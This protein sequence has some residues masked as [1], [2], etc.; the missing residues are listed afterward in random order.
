MNALT[1]LTPGTARA[2]ELPVGDA[3]RSRATILA[4]TALSAAPAI[5]LSVWLAGRAADR[6]MTMDESF[7]VLTTTRSWWSLV[8]GCMSDPGMSVYYG[9]LKLWT[10]VAGT[11][12]GHLRAFSVVAFAVACLGAGWLGSR[13]GRPLPVG[14][15]LVAVVLSPMVREALS[16]ARAATLGIA[17]AVWLL[18]AFDHAGSD[19]ARP[20]RLQ[21]AL[22]GSLFLAF[23]HPSTLFLGGAGIVFAWRAAR[24]AGL[25]RERRLAVAAGVFAGLGTASAL[26]KSGVT[27][28]A[29]PG[30]QGLGEVL[31][32]LPGGRVVAGVA[33][34]LSALVLLAGLCFDTEPVI[35]WFGGAGLAWFAA[36]LLVL[37]V[38]NLWVPRYFSAA[39]VL[40]VVAIA[41]ARIERWAAPMSALILAVALLGGVERI[42]TAY[43][44]GSTWC[45]VADALAAR[46][47]PGDRLT[48]AVSSYQ[49]PVIACLGDEA[50]SVLERGTTVPFLS[51]DRYEDPRGLW[52]GQLPTQPELLYLEPGHTSRIVWLDGIDVPASEAVEQLR[53][54]GARC[55]RERFGDVD[56]A[57][58]TQP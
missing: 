47:E 29:K 42:D 50:R 9:L 16:D 44:Y 14:A 38:R 26:I 56:L 31:G 7:T 8:R 18:V 12:L 41:F 25:D 21:V 20:R 49:S 53:L 11:S 10:F 55:D 19:V 57:T 28:V 13:R 46:I 58:C 40:V 54:N 6:P 45:D 43:G 48:F 27:T 24:R 3:A 34:L 23:T 1:T 35:R 32:Q 39:M 37:P 22:G 15:A 2:P 5:V 33:L 30:L 4:G 51:G 52:F 17:G 36:N